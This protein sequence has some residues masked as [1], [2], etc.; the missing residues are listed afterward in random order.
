MNEHDD[1]AETLRDAV[2]QLGSAALARWLKGRLLNHDQL[3]HSRQAEPSYYL[4]AKL[5]PLLDREVQRDMERLYVQMITEAAAGS[6]PPRAAVSLLLLA[7]PILLASPSSLV[8][9]ATRSLRS[10][11]E[12]EVTA[13]DVCLAALQALVTVN[14]STAPR[15]WFEILDQR[16]NDRFIATIVEA[17]ART[18]LPELEEWLLSC[19]PHPKIE[20]A[21]FGILPLLISRRGSEESMRLMAALEPHMSK[22][23]RKRLAS[24]IARQKIAM[25]RPADDDLAVNQGD[26]FCLLQGNDRTDCWDRQEQF[27]SALER[28]R[29]SLTRYADRVSAHTSK[30]MALWRVYLTAINTALRDTELTAVAENDLMETLSRARA[31][32]LVKRV[33]IFASD[34]P[35]LSLSD[36]LRE[37]ILYQLS[38]SPDEQHAS[39]EFADRNDTEP[40]TN[41]DIFAKLQK[42]DLEGVPQ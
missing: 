7:D 42:M 15:F 11:A 14:Y 26:V 33:A 9:S 13:D 1:S 20:S 3:F 21:V 39:D 27:G 38:L 10:L 30:L 24:F 18:A 12:T 36:E 5:Y 40:F 32:R 23:S 17:L 37:A 16:D 28:Y 22:P 8:D 34:N 4:I 2:E 35:G 6:W 19:L 31:A 29:Q 25:P 41:A